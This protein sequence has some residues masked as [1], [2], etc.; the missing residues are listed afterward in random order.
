MKN[1]NNTLK[2]IFLKAQNLSPAVAGV[3]I[4]AAGFLVGEV[5]AALYALQ[6]SSVKAP[7]PQA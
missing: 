1:M 3:A 7:K 5:P 4:A 6:A 2:N